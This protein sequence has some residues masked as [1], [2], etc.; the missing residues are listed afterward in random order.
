MDP[1]FYDTNVDL[2]SSCASHVGITGCKKLKYVWAKRKSHNIETKF[3]Q[4][5]FSSP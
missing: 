2:K 5:P 4:N 1:I 3:N